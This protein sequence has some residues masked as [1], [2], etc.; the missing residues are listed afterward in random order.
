MC[1]SLY[2][3]SL[4]LFFFFPQRE[5][6][7][8]LILDQKKALGNWLYFVVSSLLLECPAKYSVCLL[9]WFFIEFVTNTASVLMSWLQGRW[10]LSSLTRDRTCVPCIGRQSLNYQTTREVLKNTPEMKKCTCRYLLDR[11]PYFKSESLFNSFN[12][13]LR[14]TCT[15]FLLKSGVYLFSCLMLACPSEVI[16]SELVL[17]SI[18]RCL[19]II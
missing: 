11:W 12:K 1:P 13:H 6:T 2:P 8:L 7:S 16:N 3:E 18:S 19:I 15:F 4:F 14:S 9:V 5:Q 10:G 17:F